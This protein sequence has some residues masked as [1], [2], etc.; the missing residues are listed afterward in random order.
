MFWIEMEKPEGTRMP[1]WQR[2]AAISDEGIVFV[3]AAI[4]GNEQEVFLCANFD[5]TPITNYLKHL[6]VPAK[7]LSKEFPE[8]KEV[9]DI[10]SSKVKE[11]HA[12]SG[13]S[14]VN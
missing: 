3:P 11:I 5:G 1:K 9:C 2:S 8:T 10:I 14:D 4:A 6:F 12:S 13:E 7:W